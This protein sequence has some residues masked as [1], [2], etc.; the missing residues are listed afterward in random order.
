MIIASWIVTPR[1]GR[2]AEVESAIG[3]IPGNRVVSHPNGLVVSTES[4]E[5]DL[6]MT[7]ERLSRTEGVLCVMLVSAFPDE[8]EAAA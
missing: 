8:P 3:A 4:P 5:R 2:Q 6:A 1:A 7:H